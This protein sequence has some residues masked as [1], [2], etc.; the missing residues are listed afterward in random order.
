M[1]KNRE[2]SLGELTGHGGLG[3]EGDSG[4]DFD[5]LFEGF[6]IIKLHHGRKSEPACGQ[7][8]IQPLPG[9][10]FRGKRDD[11]VL[12]KIGKVNGTFFEQRVTRCA[13]HVQGVFFEGFDLEAFSG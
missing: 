12:R 8:F 4:I 5:G 3:E 1:G 11:F 6:H 2:G 13:D 7:D 9:W 10:H